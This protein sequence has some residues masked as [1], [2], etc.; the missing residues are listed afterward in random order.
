MM[1]KTFRLDLTTHSTHPINC[2]QKAGGSEK[3]TEKG[4]QKSTITRLLRIVWNEKIPEEWIYSSAVP[5]FTKV[6]IP[7]AKS[8]VV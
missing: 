4:A 6:K 5:V 8:S 2:L 1:Q 3:S 7:R